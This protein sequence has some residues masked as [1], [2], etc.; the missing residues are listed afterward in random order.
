MLLARGDEPAAVPAVSK[1]TQE[2]ATKATP[3]ASTNSRPESAAPNVIVIETTPEL[4]RSEVIGK[5][6]EA[7]VKEEIAI[8]SDETREGKPVDFHASIYAHPNMPGE[9][10]RTLIKTL[11]EL[12]I[13]HVSIQVGP[14]DGES[15]VV[16]TCPMDVTFP[17]IRTLYETLELQNDFK[18]DLLVAANNRPVSLTGPPMFKLEPPNDSTTLWMWKVVT[19]PSSTTDDDSAEVPPERQG[20]GGLGNE[21]GFGGGFGGAGGIGSIVMGIP[22]SAIPGR[23]WVAGKKVIVALSDDGKRAFAYSEQHPR[24]A[25]QDLEP[26]SG[27]KAV[28]PV[29]E[30]DVAA[31]Q[32]GHICYAY[33]ATLGTWDVLKLPEGESAVPS[34][35]D[36]SISV[37]SA[38]QGDFVYKN[39]WGKWFSAEE[40]KA[41]RVAEICW[42][43]ETRL[44]PIRLTDRRQRRS[45]SSSI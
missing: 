7:L 25:S 8:R 15:A 40:I 23:K 42:H 19:F 34:V 17:R 28:V 12:S 13:G 16:V 29:Q 4:E 6:V 5:L 43:N 24:W 33:S 1:P 22:E 3:E 14:A 30:G 2:Q 41:G 31:V 9:K 26:V 35:C 36:D 44:R 11:T 39:A 32:L 18:V 38:S 10:I 27:A 45:S 21:F 20:N 37:H